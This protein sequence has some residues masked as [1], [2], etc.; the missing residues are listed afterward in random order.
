MSDDLATIMYIGIALL[1][2][3]W[4]GILFRHIQ[5]EHAQQFRVFRTAFTLQFFAFS[6]LAFLTDQ[7]RAS[8]VGIDDRITYIRYAFALYLLVGIAVTLL[9]QAASSSKNE[10]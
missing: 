2:L 10:A 1:N 5:T 8:T 4:F 9:Y 3:Y 6:A 7:D